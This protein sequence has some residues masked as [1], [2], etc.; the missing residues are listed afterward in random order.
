[1]PT[2]LHSDPSK[3]ISRPITPGSELNRVRQ[4]VSLMT[5]TFARFASSS[6]ENVRPAIAWTPST[7]NS[8]AVTHCLETVSAW[9]S[10]P[11][12]TIPPTLGVKP[13]IF[14]NVRLRAFQSSMLSG[15][16]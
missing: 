7:S 13:A 3:R 11:A 8:P 1:M 2:T 16:T 10:A 12:I 14:S 5:I 4:S 9:P 15:D 6:A